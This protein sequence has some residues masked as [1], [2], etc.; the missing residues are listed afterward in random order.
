MYS[1]LNI[2]TFHLQTPNIGKAKSFYLCNMKTVQLDINNAKTKKFLEKL[3]AEKEA[4]LA[5]LGK[6]LKTLKAQKAS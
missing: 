1:D 5:E 4:K 6:F 2:N 3:E